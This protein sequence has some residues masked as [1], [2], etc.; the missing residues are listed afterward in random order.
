MPDRTAVCRSLSRGLGIGALVLMAAVASSGINAPR[1]SEVAGATREPAIA[2]R[3]AP[4]ASLKETLQAA[5][6]LVDAG[7]MAAPGP[8]IDWPAVQRLHEAWLRRAPRAAMARPASSA[9]LPRPAGAPPQAG[10]RAPLAAPDAFPD[11][12]FARGVWDAVNALRAEAGLRPVTVEVRLQHAATGYASLMAGTNW[13]SHTGPDGSSFVDR[14]AA[15]GFP[16]DTQVGE[17]LALAPEGSDPQALA[18]AWL[19]SPA[20]RAQILGPYSRAGLAC[21]WSVDSAG[22]RIVRCVMEFAS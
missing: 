18:R 11:A 7:L 10:A 8:S 15:A 13:F 3:P 5:V 12:E 20:H 6:I 1:A 16:F 19:D 14:L 4:P 9:S 21:A 22:A 17:V 2:Y